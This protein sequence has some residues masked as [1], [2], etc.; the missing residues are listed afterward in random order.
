MQD[1]PTQATIAELIG[2]RTGPLLS[3]EYFPP[4]SAE[5]EQVFWRTVAALSSWQP[6]FVSV[7]YGA[8]GSTRERTITATEKLAAASGPVTVG[9]LTCV[10]QSTDD[11]VGALEGYR[12][13]GINNILA[14][15]GDMPEGP[16]QPWEPHP[17][18]LENATQLVRLVKEHGDF[19]VGVAAFPNPHQPG[20]DPDLDA[21]L[22]VA[23]AEAG[24]DYAITQ[25]FFEAERY[26]ELVERVR[27]LGSDIPIIPG[28]MPLTVITQIERFAQLSGCALPSDFV[29]Q[30]REV[31][32]DRDEV[33]RRGLAR[34]LR[35]CEQ[36]VE[37]GAP[38]LQFFTQNRA[39]ATREVLAK[40]P[41]YQSRQAHS[42][43]GSPG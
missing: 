37:A 41:C 9:H 24:A 6:D 33:R 43:V 10:S 2:Q 8:N 18:G 13:A 23:K 4:R 15:R 31:A 16:Q 42:S 21:R 11:I 38:G 35:L 30:L 14:V 36:L 1:V 28:V 26:F 29:S 7:T 32:D 5:E 27:A 3:F 40:L 22:V 12:R 20:N 25:L 39:K 17:T 34:A 19:C